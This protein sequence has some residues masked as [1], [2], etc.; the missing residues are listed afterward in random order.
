MALLRQKNG[1]TKSRTLVGH[2]TKSRTL[3]FV[4]NLLLCVKK[5][6]EECARKEAQKKNVHERRFYVFHLSS[7][8][9]VRGIL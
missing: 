6:D 5:R 7:S 2:S 4:I 8:K 1:R 3:L 9:A